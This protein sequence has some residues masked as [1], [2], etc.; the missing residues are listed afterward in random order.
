MIIATSEFTYSLHT[1]ITK[2]NMLKFIDAKVIKTRL[3]QAEF[4]YEKQNKKQISIKKVKH[5]EQ[6]EAEFKSATDANSSI[7]ENNLNATIV[8]V[9]KSPEPKIKISERNQNGEIIK[10]PINTAK[11]QK[12]R[13]HTPRSAH[14][15][16]D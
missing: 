9:E 12:A 10:S 1:R 4:E 5:R 16:K 15:L 6:N 3:E 14:Q 2:V 11:I 8:K 13:T 7:E